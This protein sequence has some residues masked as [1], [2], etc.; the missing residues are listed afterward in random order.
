MH[1]LLLFLLNL[2][3]VAWLRTALVTRP[4]SS[5]LDRW[6]AELGFG[7]LIALPFLASG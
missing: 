2:S 7:F 3:L 4:G 1:Q 5:R 6:Y